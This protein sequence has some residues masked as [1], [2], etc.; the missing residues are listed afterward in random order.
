MNTFLLA[1]P[2]LSRPVPSHLVR[3]PLFG[4]VELLWR[5]QPFGFPFVLEPPPT[6]TRFI[7]VPYLQRN[8]GRN[9]LVPT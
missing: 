4:L 1:P 9:L 7:H 6:N 8:F 2:L 3:S 5:Q